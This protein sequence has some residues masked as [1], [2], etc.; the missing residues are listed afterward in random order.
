MSDIYLTATTESN[1][2]VIDT[3][4]RYWYSGA[5]Q[6]WQLQC[7]AWISQEK[8][9]GD[10]NPKTT[11]KYKWRVA[12]SGYYPFWDD[13]HVYT[14]EF[15][16]KSDSVSFSLPQNKAD[17]IR[18]MCSARTL[19]TIEHDDNGELS[20]TF[21]FSGATCAGYYWNG[22]YADWSLVSESINGSVPSL[23]PPAPPE[24]EPPTPVDPE[25]EPPTPLEFDDDP[26]YYVYCDGELVYSAGVEGR[27]I[28]NPVLDLEVNK[29]GSFDFDLPVGSAMYDRISK[30]KST[31][32]VCQG[33]EILFRGRLLDTERNINNTISCKCEGFLAWLNDISFQP[34]TFSGTARDLLRMHIRRYNSRASDFRKIDYVYSDVS[35]NLSIEK[36]EYSN[37]WKEIKSTIV[38]SMGGYI[39]PYLTAETTGVQWLS[40]YG[41]TTSQVIQ[42]GKNL[43]DFKEY[44]DAS[45]VFTAVRAFGKEV[46][47]ERIGLTGNDGFIVDDNAVEM[48]GR[49]ERTVFF[50]EITK[51][52]TLRK[53]A[54]DYLRKGIEA[55][56]TI[57][58][59]AADMHLLDPS[60]ERIRLGDSVRSVSVPHGI[61]AYFLCTKIKLKLDHP[62]DSE[63]I[64]GYSQRKISD[65]TDASYQKFVIT[66]GDD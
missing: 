2:Q 35:A 13:S 17:G 21:Y 25:P 8:A 40:S 3:W 46:D 42:F 61:D 27:E 6:Y 20:G 5:S 31:I 10:E 32:E 45:E 57:K 65:L 55:A 24:P 30:L 36:K 11:I 34:Y 51:E 15:G 29:A 41:S 19:G 38:D 33:N 58:L 50:D 26:H 9:K 4:T 1:P 37:A 22:S 18:D 63:Y 44:I 64:F 60:A 47:G 66:E 48:F 16:G 12:Q 7:V 56:T 14:L 59:K 39:V 28:L 23:D 52:S 62:K 54:S 43:L 49:I 53:V